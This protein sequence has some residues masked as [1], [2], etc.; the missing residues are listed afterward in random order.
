MKIAIDIRNIGR[1]KTG[2]EVVVRELVR[3]LVQIDRKNQYYLITDTDDE[4]IIKIIIEKLELNGKDN[5]RI[6]SINGSNKFTWAAWSVWRWLR[7][8]QI[9]VYH[10]EYIVPFFIP[11]SVFVI[12]HIHDV[13]FAALPQYIGMKDLYFLRLLIPYSLRRADK[14]IAVSQFTRDEIIR[15]YD[16]DRRKIEVVYNGIT[17]NFLSRAQEPE[18]ALVRMKY[19]LP[20][21]YIFSLGTMQPRKNIPL[22]IAAFAEISHKIP[23]YSLVLSGKKGHH[24]DAKIKKVLEKHPGVRDRVIFTGFIDDEHLPAVYAEAEVFVFPSLYEGF[25]LPLI[26]AISQGTHVL[27]SDIPIFHEIAGACATYASP[28]NL[29]AFADALYTM[30]MCHATKPKNLHCNRE[31]CLQAFSWEDAAQKM[32]K[33]FAQIL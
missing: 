22:L 6:V 8:E 9:D 32:R 11:R 17:E 23:N 13:S 18:S 20:Q 4:E 25:G 19:K 1:H 31:N 26:E 5:V 14:I 30:V 2:S 27:A 33:I 16:I 29:D 3:H 10:T 28:K 12:T 15:F 21:K 24:F 7:K